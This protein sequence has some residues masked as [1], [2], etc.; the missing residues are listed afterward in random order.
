LNREF[1]IVE[2]HFTYEDLYAAFRNFDGMLN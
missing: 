1:S 2:V